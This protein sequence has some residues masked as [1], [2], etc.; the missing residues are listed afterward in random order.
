MGYLEKRFTYLPQLR[1]FVSPQHKMYR[2]QEFITPWLG[3]LAQK[4]E[5]IVGT[6]AFKSTPQ[7]GSL[8]IAYFTF[9]EY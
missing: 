1:K 5:K 3:S 6:C 2:R 7:N 4:D 9:P 8:E